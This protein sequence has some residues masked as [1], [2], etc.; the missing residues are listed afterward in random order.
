MGKKTISRKKGRSEEGGR[1]EGRKEEKGNL[2]TERKDDY[3]VLFRE[4]NYK[5]NS[6]ISL[7]TKVKRWS[8]LKSCG[9]K[10]VAQWL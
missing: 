8:L 3:K 4:S 9:P 5:E 10:V 7:S 2:R 1:K 6:G